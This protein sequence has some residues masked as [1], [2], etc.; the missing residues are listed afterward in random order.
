MN[1]NTIRRSITIAAVVAAAALISPA[2]ADD[3]PAVDDVVTSAKVDMLYLTSEYLSASTI[4]VATVGGVV[5]LTG[6]VD[7]GV[8]YRLAEALARTVDGVEDVDNQLE[9]Y[10]WKHEHDEDA[11][12]KDRDARK[13]RVADA[14]LAAKVD[15]QLSYHDQ[16]VNSDID[17]SADSGVISLDGVV[18]TQEQSQVAENAAKNTYGVVSVDNKLSVAEDSVSEN[19]E[20]AAVGVM[21]GVRDEWVEKRVER[22]IAF[23]RTLHVFDLNIEVNNQVCI[24]SGHVPTEAQRTLAAT[25]ASST[26]GVKEIVN[27]IVVLPGTE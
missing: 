18:A 15:G 4:D 3:L 12:R 25:I 26:K 10:D 2:L 6:H 14:N 9:I 24:L 27:E 8:E 11:S 16:L 20:D 23:N 19:L 5:T 1:T 13:Q 17:V 22:R 7:D 21:E